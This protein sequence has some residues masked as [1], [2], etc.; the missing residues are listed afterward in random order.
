MA[1]GLKPWCP[2]PTRSF[3][4]SFFHYGI[5]IFFVT[6]ILFEESSLSEKNQFIF[7]RSEFAKQY[8]DILKN[9]TGNSERTY[10]FEYEFLPLSPLQSQDLENVCQLL[11]SRGLR[12]QG[13]E[14]ISEDNIRISFEP[15]GQIEYQSPPFKKADTRLFESMI[16]F[17]DHTNVSIKDELGIDYIGVGFL[18]GRGDAPLCNQS[19]RYVTLHERLRRTGTRGVE[20]MKGTASIHLHVNIDGLDHLLPMFYKLCELASHP[21]FKMSPERRDIWNHTD[22]VRCGMP[23]CCFA[24]LE[25]PYELTE[26]LI[27]F[28]L[29]AEVLGEDVPFWRAKDKTFDAFLYHMTTLFTDIR[30]NLK[31]PTLEL[32]TLDS[33]PTNQFYHKWNL[34]ISLLE[35]I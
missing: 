22:P 11:F 25:T 23:P 30:F 26:R 13:Y 16:E 3:R 6:H 2:K 27:D 10:G 24:E 35:T 5:N 21:D 19:P 31:G 12:R 8:I 7:L 1:L 4:S 20:M 14:F 33:M 15:G 29:D 17:M 28:A 34:F 18:P 32:R 9:R